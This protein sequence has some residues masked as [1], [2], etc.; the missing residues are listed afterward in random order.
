MPPASRVGYIRGHG[1][2]KEFHRTDAEKKE[3]T[4]VLWCFPVDVSHE[5]LYN[6]IKPSGQGHFQ[7]MLQTVNN[8]CE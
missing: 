3:E 4:S 1:T 8:V 6:G 2:G 5:Q 7:K